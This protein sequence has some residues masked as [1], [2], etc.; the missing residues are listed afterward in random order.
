MNKIEGWVLNCSFSVDSGFSFCN[1]FKGL[2]LFLIIV[3]MWGCANA[4][5]VHRGPWR[6]I[7]L[8]LEL[9]AVGNC[10]AGMLGT[11][12]GDLASAASAPNSESFLQPSDFVFSEAVVIG[13]SS[14]TTWHFP[15]SVAS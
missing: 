7:P 6:Q 12:P 15:P 10:P 9:R 2:L 11:E 13:S 5:G 1:S 3:C 14:E 8:E 4:A